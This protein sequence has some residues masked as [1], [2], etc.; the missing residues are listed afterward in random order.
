MVRAAARDSSIELGVGDDIVT[1]FDESNID[2]VIKPYNRPD[3]S[4][5]AVLVKTAVTENDTFDEATAR[6]RAFVAG[7]PKEGRTEMLLQSDWNLTIVGVEQYRPAM[8]ALIAEDARATAAAFGP[9][10]EVEIDGLQ[11]TIQWVQSGPLDLNLFIDY[12]MQIS[13]G[14]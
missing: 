12:D 5:A 8:L 11:A 13:G 1:L 9:D 2:A 3:S 10:Y 6:V 14:D 4:Y 7:A